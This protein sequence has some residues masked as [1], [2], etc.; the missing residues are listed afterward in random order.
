MIA[1]RIRSSGTRSNAR[2]FF[3]GPALSQSKHV[4]TVQAI[5]AAFQRGDL[6]GILDKLSDDVTWAL[7]ISPDIPGLDRVALFRPRR[8]KTT[9]PEYFA[10]LGQYFMFHAFEPVDYM[11]SSRRVAALLR[12]NHTYKPTGRRTQTETVQLFTFNADGLVT[13][14]QEFSDTAILVAL[15][16]AKK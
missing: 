6:Q 8:G 3:G 14:F 1:S 7:N 5:Y 16:A 9:I 11:G 15:F 10:S 2:S 13:D 12:L 4:A